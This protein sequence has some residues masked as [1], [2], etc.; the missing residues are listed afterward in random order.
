ML[1]FYPCDSD[2]PRS[3]LPRLWL[4]L[5]L[6]F[7]LFVA[8]GSTGLVWWMRA[9]AQHESEAVFAT[10][11]RANADFVRQVRLGH[12]ARTAR[13]LGTVLG[14]RVFF[15]TPAGFVPEPERR[16]ALLASHLADIREETPRPVAVAG[17]SE[18]TP[19]WDVFAARVDDDT[20]MLFVRPATSAVA[21]LFRRET[22]AVL[23]AFWALS[24]ALAWALTRNLVRPAAL[25]GRMAAGLAHEIHNPLSSIRLH[26]QLLE[27]SAP[28]ARESLEIMQGETQRIESLVNQW[29]FL[30]RPAPP[31]T[32]DTELAPLVAGIVR[33]HSAQA[34]HAGVKIETDIAAGLTAK[35][36]ARRLSQAIGNIVINAL[37]A[38][39]RGGTLRIST[40]PEQPPRLIFEDTGPGFTP[41]AL[42]HAADLFFSE[43]EGGMGIGLNVVSE[44]VKA[45]GGTLQIS[46]R[47]PGGAQVTLTLPPGENLQSAI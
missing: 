39:P 14:V 19:W 28:E 22:L 13:D 33:A 2:M 44:I 12:S 35:V 6:P 10:L 25:L 7:A 26:A 40:P 46:N 30:A 36:D 47:E 38:M 41:D 16:L 27:S 31:Q 11:A 9:Q 15:K 43:K 45:H 18:E 42:A 1:T 5:A 21:F 17:W 3:R 8:L 20:L 34:T 37:Q 29:M 32:A 4:R 23:A 24:F